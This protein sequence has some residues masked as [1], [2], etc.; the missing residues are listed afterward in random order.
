MHQHRTWPV[1]QP[2]FLV[3]VCVCLCVYKLQIKIPS[4]T[5]KP[6]FEANCSTVAH[7]AS[8][9]ANHQRVI[10]R[11]TGQMI[12]GQLVIWPPVT[13]LPFGSTH[14]SLCL[15]GIGALAWN[16][17]WIGF[18]KD[19]EMMGVCCTDVLWRLRSSSGGW[20]TLWSSS[21]ETN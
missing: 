12:I 9:F 14:R 8:A 10:I 17:H 2:F 5:R 13:S 20:L 6:K 7:P 1:V 18:L 15:D 4:S 3:C 16:E 21:T 11:R 19:L